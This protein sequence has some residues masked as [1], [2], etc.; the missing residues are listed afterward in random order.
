L[1][2]IDNEIQ[3]Q[4]RDGQDHLEFF[5]NLDDAYKA[6]QMDR[7]IWK[8]SFQIGEHHFRMRPKTIRN[9]WEYS[10]EAKLRNLSREYD[11]AYK[12]GDHQ[13][14]VNV[15]WVH[16]SVMRSSGLVLGELTEVKFYLEENRKYLPKKGLESLLT[17][18]STAEQ[19]ENKIVVM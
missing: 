6:S 12:R 10:S 11:Q 4:T 16:Q 17:I 18:I 2:T 13:P 3:Y 15:F 1:T 9:R 19:A 5:G 14:G 8:I 7:S